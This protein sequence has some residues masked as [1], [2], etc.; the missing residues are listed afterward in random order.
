M[1]FMLVLLCSKG[2][3]F[4]P[5]HEGRGNGRF[6]ADADWADLALRLERLLVVG[7]IIS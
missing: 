4:G 7:A 1:N 3:S 2:P 5:S 6:T